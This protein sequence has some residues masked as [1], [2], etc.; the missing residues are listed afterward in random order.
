MINKRHQIIILIARD[1]KKSSS[2][3]SRVVRTS[4]APELLPATP[5]YSDTPRLTR[6]AAIAT[7]LELAPS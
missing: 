2:Q 3:V 6:G 1:L 4:L 5:S 7:C